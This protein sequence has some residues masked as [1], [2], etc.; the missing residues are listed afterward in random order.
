MAENTRVLIVD[1]DSIMRSIIEFAVKE[2]GCEVVGVAEDGAVAVDLFDRTRPDFV[3][4]D[5]NLPKMNGVDVLRRIREIEPNAYVV[6]MTSVD[7]EDVIEECLIAGARD[8][9]RKDL[10]GDEIATRLDRHLT[11]LTLP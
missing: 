11:R 7:Q 9:I 1:D 10:S 3:M 6:M 5:I 4:L 2:Y 8:Y